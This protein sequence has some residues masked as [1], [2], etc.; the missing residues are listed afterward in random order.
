MPPSAAGI[1]VVWL[2]SILPLVVPHSE[3]WLTG[4]SRTALCALPWL[5]Y[6]GLPRAARAD[7]RPAAGESWAFLALALSPLALAASLDVAAGMDAG[8][9][10][11]LALASF[12]FALCLHFGASGSAA[13]EAGARAYALAWS[14][15]V[16][17]LPLLCAALERGGA[18][19]YGRV[20]GWLG[21]VARAS[22]LDW[23]VHALS[24]LASPDFASAPGTLVGVQRW[25]L[26]ASALLPLCLC[27]V[28]FGLGR[29]LA[30]RRA[31]AEAQT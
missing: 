2:V 8:V 20:P 25:A 23:T 5:L 15:L 28:L 3:R 29:R 14:V 13:D 30:L 6:A 31:R 7:S 11:L 16:P 21:F 4:V 26:A 22:P 1:S 27:L 10:V 9:V 12:V 18:P 17:G 24:G 19:V